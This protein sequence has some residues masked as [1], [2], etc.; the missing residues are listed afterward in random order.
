M[1]TAGRSIVAT[2]VILRIGLGNERVIEP[3]YWYMNKAINDGLQ[4]YAESPNYRISIN[5]LLTFSHS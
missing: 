2:N 5:F 4:K 1:G 3:F